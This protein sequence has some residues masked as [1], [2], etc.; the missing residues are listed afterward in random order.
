MMKYQPLLFIKTPSYAVELTAAKQ[1]EPELEESTSI[2]EKPLPNNI[3]NSLIAHQLRF[4]ARP[5][6]KNRMLLVVLK[7]GERLIGT[8]EHLNGIDVVMKVFEQKIIVNAN[9]IATIH[10]TR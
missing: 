4:F 9:D 1:Q 3:V 6:A 5:V 7:N 10:A 8:I 2:Y